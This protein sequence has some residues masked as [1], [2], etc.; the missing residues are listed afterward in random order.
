MKKVDFRGNKLDDEKAD[1]LSSCLHNVNELDFRNCEYSKK[2]LNTISS[3][4]SKVY[5]SV[6][7]C[8]FRNPIC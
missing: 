6:K 7:S 8:F 5:N 3:A 4:I 1:I 2:A